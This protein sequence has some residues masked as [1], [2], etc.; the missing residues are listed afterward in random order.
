[1]KQHW[2]FYGRE[3]E[4]ARLKAA[5]LAPQFGLVAIRGRRVVGKSRLLRETVRG[6]PE[7]RP[8]FLFRAKPWDSPEDLQEDLKDALRRARAKRPG[9]GRPLDSAGDPLRDLPQVLESLLRRGVGVAI[10]DA[11]YLLS[12][13]LP[14]LALEIAAMAR[15]LRREAPGAGS[16]LLSDARRGALALAGWDHLRTRDLLA[17]FGPAVTISMP[18]EP[19]PAATLLAVARDRGWLGWPRRLALVRAA[20][21]GMPLD[22]ARFSGDRMADFAAWP[23]DGEWRRAFAERIVESVTGWGNVAARAASEP[24]ET[25]RILEHIARSPEGEAGAGALRAA[26]PDM[27]PDR[28]EARL[29]ELCDGRL[30]LE[31]VPAFPGPSA[32]SELALSSSKGQAAEGGAPEERWRIYDPEFRFWVDAGM[33]R[34][35]DESIRRYSPPQSETRLLAGRMEAM[36]QAALEQF[37]RDCGTEWPELPERGPGQAGQRNRP[38]LRKACPG[39]RLPSRTGGGS[40]AAPVERRAFAFGMTAPGVLEGVLVPYGVPIRIGDRFEEVFKPGSLT[41]NGLLVNVLQAARDP[42]GRPLARP[43]KGLELHDGPGG[44]RA[45]LTLP[46]TIDGRRV[47]ARVDAGELTAFSAAFQAI[48]EDWPAPDRRIVLRA[49]LVGL[50]LTDRPEDESPLVDEVSARPGAG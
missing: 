40:G 9:I 4:M 37:R 3:A 45:T 33:P 28:L 23:D 5:F 48:E 49:L 30:R 44:L 2:R 15:R 20:Y 17:A 47:R 29:K 21:G 41:V 14:G 25:L 31:T 38:L 11:H 8:A 46:D 32:G 27:A 26:F 50:S 43:G 35:F 7:D 10:D 18:L 24:P 19:W 39:P 12:D 42:R 16:G 34:I 22:W 1:M 36:E 6:L 13:R